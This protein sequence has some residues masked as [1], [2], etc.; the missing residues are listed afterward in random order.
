MNRREVVDEFE[1][2]GVSK[3]E[4]TARINSLSNE[5]VME[6][7][8]RLDELPE[9]GFSFGSSGCHKTSVN[10]RVVSESRGCDSPDAGAVLAIIG[11]LV[12]VVIFFIWLFRNKAEVY[13]PSSNEG[14]VS[15]PVV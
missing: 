9:G 8:G 5:E 10:G 13:S 14:P 15:E 4:A 1:K 3:V 7:A 12:L 11:I 2:Y 6:I